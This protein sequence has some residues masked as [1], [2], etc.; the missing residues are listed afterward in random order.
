MERFFQI[1]GKYDELTIYQLLARVDIN[2]AFSL[3]LNVFCDLIRKLDEE[4][5]KEEIRN[6]W[7]AMLPFMSAGFL[8]YMSFNDYFD[9]CTGKNI[10]LR[11]DEEIL[12]D[13]KEI[14]K[15]IKG[16]EA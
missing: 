14:R 15:Q 10:D 3:P 9:Q 7:T 13:A 5:R 8:K 1:I 16:K 2:F 4:K 11:P 6:Q 12:D